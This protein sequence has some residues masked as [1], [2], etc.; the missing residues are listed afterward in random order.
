MYLKLRHYV[1]ITQRFDNQNF[2]AGFVPDTHGYY[3][4]ADATYDYRV[5]QKLHQRDVSEKI[6]EFIRESDNLM[7]LGDQGYYNGSG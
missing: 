6:L 2:Q 5:R 3:E 4:K 1:L 7:V